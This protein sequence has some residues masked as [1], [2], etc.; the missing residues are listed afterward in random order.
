VRNIFIAEIYTTC[1]TVQSGDRCISYAIFLT[2]YTQ[3]QK[4]TWTT[5]KY[6]CGAVQLKMYKKKDGKTMHK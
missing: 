6:T 5:K 4:S 1:I 3:K 2:Q